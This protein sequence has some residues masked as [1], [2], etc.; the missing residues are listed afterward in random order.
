MT[1]LLSVVVVGV[2]WSAYI[3][4]KRAALDASRAHLES[5]GRQIATLLD[6]SLRRARREL[7]PLAADPRILAELRSQRTPIDPVIDSLLEAFQHRTA[8]YAAVSIWSS[9]GVRLASS[10][11]PDV[12]E[13]TGADAVAGVQRGLR[14]SRF[15]VL[16]DTLAYGVVT[17]VLAAHDVVGYVVASAR[18]NSSRNG[19]AVSRLLGP[20]VRLLV[21]NAGGGLWTDLDSVVPGPPL[22]TLGEERATYTD[23]VGA[24]YL[25]VAAT[26]PAAPWTVRLE[27]PEDFALGVA[28]GYV[29]G[30]V[31]GGVL[32]VFVGA[33]GAW[34][35]VRGV[36]RRLDEV[37][38]A[39]E[40]LAVGD[41]PARV[42]DDRGDEIGSLAKSFNMMAEHVR[43]ANQQ[44]LE[45]AVVLER[46][47]Q[48]VRDSEARY[49]Q[50]VDQ[51]PDAVLVHRDGT[52]VFANKASALMLGASSADALIGTAIFD[53]VDQQH[54]D[55]ARRRIG[56]IKT[57]QRTSRLTELPLRKLD[58]TTF[59]AEVSGTP[60]VFDREPCIQTLAR[61]VSERK[62][63]EAQFHQSQKMEAVGRLAGGVAHD[64]NNLLTII[65]T[66]SELTLARMSSD[67]P[68]RA[69]IECIRA[70]GISAAKLTR[71][72]LAFSRKQVLTPRVV[73]IN[74]AIT[75]LAGMLSRVLGDHVHVVTELRHGLAPVFADAGQ[76]EQ[77][78]MNLAVN[79]HDAMP[80]GGTL[81][82]ETAEVELGEGTEDYRRSIPPGRYVMLGV[83]D[84]GTGMTAH[85]KEHLFEPF[86]TTKQPGRGTGLGLAT[87]YG[88]VKQ[89][90]GYIWVYSEPGRGSTFK[91]YLPRYSGDSDDMPTATDEFSVP[92]REA[93]NILVVEDD[94]MVRGAVCR[95]LD[96]SP[97]HVSEAASG[98][99][100]LEIFRRC[101]GR[102]DLVI[103][104]M[105][106]PSMTGAEL[107]RE[108]RKWNP[109]L[110]AIIMSGYSEEAT[111][112]D[113]R[114]PANCAFVEKPISPPRFLRAV[115]EAL[116]A[117]R[118]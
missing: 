36:T 51:S 80:D 14:V 16:R 19:A 64:F 43:S 97:H 103:T 54:A 24:R 79:A 67:D 31:A 91:I 57:A 86:F 102:V 3:Q 1:L 13:A 53:L 15:F 71:Q 99:E 60:I 73:D 96:R 69:D 83:S 101:E 26:V 21:G 82:I 90:D 62:L 107:V 93:A 78:L 76:L 104:D 33:L 12:A 45:R 111:T 118:E 8:R 49:R 108:L 22:S 10:G 88:M 100:A 30:I 32:F 11:S 87:V 68:S 4:V 113:W 40:A 66:Y 52:V 18:I 2:S 48:E 29:A 35:I 77:V 109:L 34:L 94:A 17:P 55:E 75:G 46:R 27:A 63:L 95:I 81:T 39:A 59:T 20:G 9:Q 38:H 44:L 110:R 112:R 116:G 56:A 72:M 84:T 114:L 42:P 89:S 25:T 23:S 50:L 6:S 47:N 65:N 98:H 92:S 28:R 85:V 105:V 5:A 37:R 70:A 106:M 74:E 61:D 7:A 58:G 115:S 117:V 41:T